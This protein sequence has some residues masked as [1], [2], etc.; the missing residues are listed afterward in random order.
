MHESSG[1]ESSQRTSGLHTPISPKVRLR[2]GMRA[3]TGR[4]LSAGSGPVTAVAGSAHLWPLALAFAQVGGGKV[5]VLP[6]P[7]LPYRELSRA[8]R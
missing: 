4:R 7:V 6:L 1:C 2:A 3:G 8:G 5:C